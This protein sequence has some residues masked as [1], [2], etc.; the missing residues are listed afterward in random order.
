MTLQAGWYSKTYVPP[1]LTFNTIYYSIYVYAKLLHKDLKHRKME[2][3]Q[4]QDNP[5]FMNVCQD[6]CLG[7]T[8]YQ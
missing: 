1:Y 2:Q 7:I 3:K 5:R 8:H 4:T 6:I